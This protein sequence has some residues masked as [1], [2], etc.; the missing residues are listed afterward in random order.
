[1][2]SAISWRRESHINAADW[3]HDWMT[4]VA[5]SWRIESQIHPADWFHDF[6][7]RYLAIIMFAVDD[8]NLRRWRRWRRSSS[9]LRFVL[10]VVLC[11]FFSIFFI[12]IWWARFFF[13]MCPWTGICSSEFSVRITIAISWRINP[14][15][16]QLIDAMIWWKGILK[17]LSRSLKILSRSTA[18]GAFG[19][20][21]A[22]HHLCCVSSSP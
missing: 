10:T 7:K 19:A 15:S 1:M 3:C 22:D 5:I 8:G 13:C 16:T 18:V 11:S 20:A 4:V 12:Q 21:G 9:A 17:I 6:M 2:Q 14:K